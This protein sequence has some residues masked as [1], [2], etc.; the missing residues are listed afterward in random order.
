MCGFSSM[1]ERFLGF[2]R[3]NVADWRIYDMLKRNASTVNGGRRK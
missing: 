1:A 3:W 2:S